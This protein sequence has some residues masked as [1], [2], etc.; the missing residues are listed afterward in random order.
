MNRTMTERERERKVGSLVKQLFFLM[1]F[2]ILT[3]VK[4]FMLVLGDVTSCGLPVQ[5]KLFG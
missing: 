3:A 1:R 4:T 5:E 2:E